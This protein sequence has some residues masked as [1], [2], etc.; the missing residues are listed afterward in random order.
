MKNLFIVKQACFIFCFLII[1]IVLFPKP[2]HANQSNDSTSNQFIS[3]VNP[4]RISIYSTNPRASLRTQYLEIKKRNLAA[5]WLLTYDVISD[6]QVVNVTQE[7]DTSQELGLFLEV[8]PKF[9][10]AA[11]VVYNKTDSWHRAHAVFLS[12]YVQSD[13]IR[14][15]DTIFA[16]F[17]KIYGHYPTS[18][19]AWWI[20]SYS[21]EYMKHK[22][23]ITA[24]LTCADQFSTDGYEIWGQ[25]W[26]TPFYPSKMHAGIPAKTLE[27]KLDVVTTQWAARDPLNGYGRGSASLFST[28]DYHKIDYFQKLI[29]LYASSKS[30]KFGQIT[31]GLEGDFPPQTY[32]DTSFFASQLDVVKAEKQRGSINIVTMKDFSNWY[33]KSFPILSPAQIIQSDDF[34]DKKIKTIWYQSLNFRI[35]ILYNYDTKETKIRDFRTYHDNFQ[36]PYYIS[37][38]RDLNLFI[39]IPSQIDSAGN[40]DEEWVMFTD[41]LENIESGDEKVT[42]NYKKHKIRLT[43][44]N[45]EIIG[46]IKSVP[47]FL[48]KSP[49]INVEK[50]ANKIDLKPKANY[51]FS[52]QGLIFRS[53]T[54]E[55]AYF[56]KQ[57]KVILSEILIVLL[58]SSMVLFI[59]KRKIP[60]FHKGII[61]SCVL[62]LIVG[63]GC[64]WYFS[65]SQLYFV[66]QSELDALN[67]LKIMPGKKIVVFDKVCLQCSWHTVNI[68]AIFANKRNYVREITGK[69]IVYNIS[70]FNAK[71]K[72]E[73]KMELDKLNADYIYLVRFE[74]YTELAPFSPG[75]LNIEEIYSNANAQIWKVKKS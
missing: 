16:K 13:R 60:M 45:I 42:L 40:P 66:N 11:G 68:P 23:N 31:V 49:L 71:T 58:F 43:K 70:I 62:L 8:T 33:R 48:N 4:I 10:S 12:G 15:I 64:I 37:P 61:V 9:V 46:D 22:Y 73:A 17:K 24:N 36:E 47:N 27:S 65:N 41:L 52:E 19:G 1:L 74:N 32:A 28:Q 55:A 75:D 72:P 53:L 5:T 34:L 63:A 3:I 69:D 7:M 38:N 29:N 14:L 18:V 51:N 25:Y 35:N 20:D 54:Q 26:S 50:N 6:S 44:E 56:L 2:I 30:N 57:R 21:L 59:H 67:R 39:N